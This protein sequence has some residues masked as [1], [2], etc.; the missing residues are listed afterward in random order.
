[1]GRFEQMLELDK[2]ESYNFNSYNKPSISYRMDKNIWS[3]P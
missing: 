3:E 1:M 2:N